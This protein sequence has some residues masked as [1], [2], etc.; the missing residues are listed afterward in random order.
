MD[1]YKMWQDEEE[2]DDWGDGNPTP[3]EYRDRDGYCPQCHDVL[4]LVRVQ[5]KGKVFPASMCNHCGWNDTGRR[6]KRIIK[7]A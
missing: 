2:E 5:D 3:L 4:S 6:L 1:G 7:T